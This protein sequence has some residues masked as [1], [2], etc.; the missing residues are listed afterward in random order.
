VGVAVQEVV[1]LLGSEERVH[2]RSV[3]AVQDG[4]ALT[5]EFEVGECAVEGYGDRLG[6]SLQAL[7]IKIA[8]APDD[9]A[10]EAGQ[11]IQQV[12]FTEV[13]AVDEEGGAALL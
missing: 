7:P 6:V 1:V 3:V 10:G 4:D 5:V 13:A 11:V 8:V 9:G 12:R 2:V